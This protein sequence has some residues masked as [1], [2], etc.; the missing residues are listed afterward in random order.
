MIYLLGGVLVGVLLSI[1]HY[2][3]KIKEKLEEHETRLDG[4]N[5]VIHHDIRNRLSTI[6]N[7]L[8]VIKFNVYNKSS[9]SG[10]V[11]DAEITDNASH[12]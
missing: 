9:F 11:F 1:V 12:N 2:M 7:D 3:R 4:V 6:E 5:I 10:K 8:A